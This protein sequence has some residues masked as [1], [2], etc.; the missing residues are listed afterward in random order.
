VDPSLIKGYSPD[1]SIAVQ[2]STSIVASMRDADVSSVICACDPIFPA[3]FTQ[4]A[5]NQGWFPEWIHNGLYG[6]DLVL[7]SRLYDQKQWDHSFGVSTLE[8][9]PFSTTDPGYLA[10]KAGKPDGSNPRAVSASQL[11]FWM[12]RYVFDG[13]EAAGPNLTDRTFAQA[14]FSLPPL[15]IGRMATYS[16]GANGPSPYSLVDDVME[17]WWSSTRTGTDGKAGTFFYLRGGYR[18][19]LGGWPKTDPRVFVDDGS[20]Q[21]ARDPNQ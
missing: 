5:S 8:Y 12:V 2:Q 13:V 16:F 11:F 1:V 4:Q 3:Y 9:P 15:K 14:L 19:K 7:F 21:P 20:P 6:T 17:V 18:Y 10:Y